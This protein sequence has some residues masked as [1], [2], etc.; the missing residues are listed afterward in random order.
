VTE[1]IAYR[2]WPLALPLEAHS[3]TLALYR[4]PR[5]P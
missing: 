3:R 4:I 1:V 2:D 5:E